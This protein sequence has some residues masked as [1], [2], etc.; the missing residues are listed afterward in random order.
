[1]IQHAINYVRHRREIKAIKRQWPTALLLLAGALRAGLTLTE[2][3]DVIVTQG[4]QPLRHQLAKRVESCD[5][6]L[7]LAEKV[8]RLFLEPELQFIRSILLFSQHSGGK[9]ADLIERSA[10]MLYARFTL[11]ERVA[12][13]T[14]EG[15]VSA[16][17]V[18]ASPFSLLLVL[19]IISPTF[20]H[21]LFSTSKGLWLLGVCVLMVSIG[22]YFVH[23]AVRIDI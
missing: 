16:W 14:A 7:P 10:D 13:L 17:I 15:R 4:P 11:L 2:A 9:T 18:G 5:A 8:N 1:M 23:R 20:T 22:L 21:P 3:L 19:S 12:V 6:W